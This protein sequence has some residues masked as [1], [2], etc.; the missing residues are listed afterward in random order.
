[1]SKVTFPNTTELSSHIR[2]FHVQIELDSQLKPVGNESQL[3]IQDLT[4]S[5]NQLEDLKMTRRK[6]NNVVRHNGGI[7]SDH[8][9]SSSVSH[10]VENSS[11]E[12]GTLPKTFH[13]PGETNTE[14]FDPPEE[15]VAESGESGEPTHGESG[16]EKPDANLVMDLSSREESEDL[17]VRRDDPEKL[18]SAGIRDGTGI[19]DGAGIGHGAAMGPSP[20]VGPGAVMGLGPVIGLGPVMGPGSVMGPAVGMEHGVGREHSIGMGHGVGIE[21]GARMRDDAGIRDDAGM[22][23]DAGM[24]D[25][26]AMGDGTGMEDDLD[27]A[28]IYGDMAE[29]DMVAAMLEE[30]QIPRS[31]F[32]GLNPEE[33]QKLL[34]ARRTCK[35]CGKVCIKRSD[36]QRHLLVHT[37]ER[38]WLCKVSM[39]G[40]MIQFFLS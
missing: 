37:G 26:A 27:D 35:F 22:R 11:V 29:G 8:S 2:S 24:R 31:Q 28:G 7:G 12:E 5:F 15:T 34:E 3:Q 30:A 20:V 23:H 16:E 6:S 9:S 14:N 38:P 25:D 13:Q 18:S 33:K 4:N 19:G 39:A 40:P 36:L 21:Q 32:L 17:P 1:M 10:S